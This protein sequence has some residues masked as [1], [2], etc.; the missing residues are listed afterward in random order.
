MADS[1]MSDAERIRQRRLAHLGGAFSSTPNGTTNTPAANASGLNASESDK[2]QSPPTNSSNPLDQFG[3]PKHEE[4]PQ[5]KKTT[6]QIKIRPRPTSPAKR[7]RDGSEK[8][9]PARAAERSQ[10]SLEVWQDRTLRG[11]FRAS[12]KPEESRDAHGHQLVFLAST[13]EDLIADGSPLLVNTEK[14]DGVITEVATAAPGGKS[15]EYLLAC[16]KRV[17]RAIRGTKFSGPED[18]KQDILKETRRLCMS[19]CVFAVTMPEMFEHEATSNPLVDHLLA[20]PDADSGICT[21]FL[22]EASS[23]FEEDESIKE[24][25][26]GAAEEL[27]RQLAGKNMLE[28]YQNYLRGMRNLMRFPLIVDAITQSSMWMPE[29]IEAHAIETKTLLGPF[30]RLSPMQSD[31]AQSYFSS[32]KTRDRGFIANAQNASRITLRTHQ[33]ELFQMADAIVKSGP[34]QRGRIL[35]WFAFCVNKNH[36]KRAMRVDPR[37]VSTDGF[38]VN[39]TS[40]LDQLCEPFMDAKFGKIDRIDVNYLRRNP[41]VDISDETKINA[42]QKA[43]DEFY[44]NHV[45]GTNNFISEVFFLTVAAHHYGTEAAQTSMDSM[46]KQVKYMEKDL[47]QFEAERHKYVNVSCRAAHLRRAVIM[48]MSSH[49][50]RG[51]WLFSSSG[52]SRPVNGSTTFGVPS[53]PRTASLSTT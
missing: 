46:R 31:V 53:T 35:D 36:K 39:I 24:A 23:R 34:A 25:V 19:Y 11:I 15:F 22:T 32:P 45:E 4:T 13:K 12:L 7:E 40:V 30:F 3:A 47:V 18:P 5:E 29:G 43:A 21:D 14:L 33:A 44:A 51:I 26:V 9:R 27:S 17:A 38:M 50:I 1:T 6:P 28:D 42:D 37:I 16:F 2:P 20:D 10:E 8:P 41:R 52:S 48:L 49:R